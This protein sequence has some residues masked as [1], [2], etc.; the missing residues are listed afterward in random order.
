MPRN[1]KDEFH[2]NLSK[3]WEMT[4]DQLNKIAKE[5]T[6]L[7]KKSEAYIRD[8]SGKG[9]IEAEILILKA[10]REGIYYELGKTIAGPSRKDRDAKVALFKKQILEINKELKHKEKLLR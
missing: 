5:V 1:N 8:I 3:I 9:K 2:Q 4:Q 7:A 10:R 6:V